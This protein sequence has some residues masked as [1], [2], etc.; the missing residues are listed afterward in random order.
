L[1]PGTR[2]AAVRRG[3]CPLYALKKENPF[4]MHS[5]KAISLAMRLLNSGN[6]NHMYLHPLV[7]F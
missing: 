2:D 3:G 5:R 1:V 4:A 6:V 7:I